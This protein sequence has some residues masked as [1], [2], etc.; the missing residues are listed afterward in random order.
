MRETNIADAF[1]A[2]AGLEPPLRNHVFAP[3]R[4]W[5]LDFAWPKRQL[6]LEV[7]GGVWTRGRH[8]RGKGFILDI[9]KYNAATLLG[10]RLFRIAP[11]MLHSGD[12]LSL[13]TRMAKAFP[14]T[15]CAT[16]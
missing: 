10:W 5:A 13:F 3:P 12:A 14:R 1:F 9:E 2:L 15:A 7:E 8:V 16:P 6:A 11:Q 4:K